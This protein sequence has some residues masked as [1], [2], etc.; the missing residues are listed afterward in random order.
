MWGVVRFVIK[1]KGTVFGS[2]SVVTTG[3]QQALNAAKRMLAGGSLEVEIIDT[4]GVVYDLAE[5]ERK[6]SESEDI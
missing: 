4:D 5:I 1:S 6:A 2:L 3:A